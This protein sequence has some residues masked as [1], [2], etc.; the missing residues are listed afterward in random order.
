MLFDMK[1]TH[2]F[3]F[4]EISKIPHGSGNEKALSDWI[5]ALARRQGLRY[6]QDD[7]WNVVVYVPASPGYEEHPGVII[8]AHMDMVCEKTPES[9]HDFASDPLELFVDHTLL[10]AKGTTLGADD[11]M[12]VAYM[13]DIMTDKSLR[14]PYLE[15]CFTVQEEVGLIGA[16]A[17][18][19]EY[20]QARRLINLDGGGEVRTYTSLSGSRSMVIEKKAEWQAVSGSGYR[21]V[22]KGLRG[23]RLGDD[24]DKERANAWKVMARIL[25]SFNQHGVQFRISDFVS[26]K[27]SGIPDRAEVF[28]ASEEREDRLRELLEQAQKE[29]LDE[30]EAN[31]PNMH[32]SL[33]RADV[34][35]AMGQTATMDL[36][37]LLYLLPYG[38]KARFL[39]LDGLPCYSTSVGRV[40]VC[41]DAVHIGYSARSPFESYMRNDQMIAETLC[42]LCGAEIVD[43]S[44]YYGYRYEKNSPLRDMMDRVYMDMYGEPL[45]HV[46][47]HGG[48]ECGAFKHLFP[49]MD[50][51]TS[52]AIYDDPHTP[53]ETLDLESFDR[54]IRFLK[55]FL[56]RL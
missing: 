50:I 48:N 14:H 37:K 28:F 45:Q 13:L 54:S 33:S 4:N 56:T 53:N 34:Q 19:A 5:C 20:F 22:V 29:L 6:L 8:Q 25:F 51:V 17:L 40:E 52:G 46:A 32:L 41:G 49:D 27:S 7:I 44:D 26:E 11:C 30:Y 3:Y 55:E 16:K 2:C 39:T 36:V 10:R 23:G 12:G 1:K 9:T 42:Q 35:R 31:D 38:V 15:L 47:A 43:I 18:K 24:I 21:C